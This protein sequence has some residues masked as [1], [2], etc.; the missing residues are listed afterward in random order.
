[1]ITEKLRRIF[2]LPFTFVL[3]VS[4]NSFAQVS[5]FVPSS[6]S[7]DPSTTVVVPVKVDSF[8]RIVSAQFTMEWDQTVLEIQKV[9]NFGIRLDPEDNFNIERDSGTA[10]FIFFDQGITA[11]GV[12]LEDSTTIFH[13]EFDVIGAP[14][15]QSPIQF[16]GSITSIE[17]ADTSFQPIPSSFFDGVV[18]VNGASSTVYNSNP[19]LIEALPPFPNPLGATTYFRYHLKH[20][21]STTFRIYDSHGRL[22]KREKLHMSKGWNEIT[23]DRTEL[24]ES[25][26]YF[27][28]LEAPEI[29]VTQQLIAQ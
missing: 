17:I 11:E 3:L 27:I 15:S 8:N 9:D 29:F 24:T 10:T 19:S 7:A 6:L 25:G 23:L 12:D 4:T 1:M 22:V 26:V 28:R 18:T 21:T 14:G 13:L 20:S 16:T 2:V 5:F